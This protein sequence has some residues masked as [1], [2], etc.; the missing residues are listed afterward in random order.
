M[1][2]WRVVLFLLLCVVAGFASS[3]GALAFGSTALGS[4]AS[5]DPATHEDGS[6]CPDSD[7]DHAP[8]GP[9]CPCTCCAGHGTV[10]AAFAPA[11]SRLVGVTPP[12]RELEP[13]PPRDLHPVEA[14]FS[15]FHPPRA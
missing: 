4:T 2:L 12:I 8:C 5:T 9:A 10:S 11:Q 7:H 3:A 6:T 15:I 13:P 14:P 1:R